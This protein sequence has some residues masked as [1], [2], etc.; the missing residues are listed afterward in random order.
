MK[1]RIVAAKSRLS[2]LRLGALLVATATRADDSPEIRTPSAPP[3]PRIS[4]PGVFGVRPE[5]AFQYHIP[6]TGGR[7]MEF[8]ADKLPAGLSLDAATGNITDKLR[9]KLWPL[10]K[11]CYPC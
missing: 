5:H 9:K 11:G 1:N 8:S 6:A 3:T 10:K 7:P 2:A 4:G